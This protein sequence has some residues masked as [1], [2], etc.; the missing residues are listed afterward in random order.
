MHHGP[1]RPKSLE[2]NGNYLGED[3]A[4]PSKNSSTV[5]FK[6]VLSDLLKW[7]KGYPFVIIGGIAVS[8][9]GK[10]RHTQDIDALILLDNE[11][12]NELLNTAA[13]PANSR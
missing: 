7:L 1:K 10:P 9:L 3:F 4:V 2:S 11:K 6:A 5:P 8:L 13:K 12:W